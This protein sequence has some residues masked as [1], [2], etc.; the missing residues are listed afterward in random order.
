MSLETWTSLI[1]QRF[2]GSRFQQNTLNFCLHM[3]NVIQRHAV[4]TQ[5]TVAAR[6]RPD[7]IRTLGSIT[8]SDLSAAIELATSLK[9]GEAYT[10]ALLKL[11][12]LHKYWLETFN[13]LGGESL[14]LQDLM[15]R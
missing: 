13:S 2:H 1:L 4:N 6:M 8:S 15:Q 10:S 3:F 12:F 14:G 11:S 5:C 9:R 7:D